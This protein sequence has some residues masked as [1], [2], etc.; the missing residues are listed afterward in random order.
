MS[1]LVLPTITVPTYLVAMTGG[2]VDPGEVFLWQQ[3][4]QETKKRSVQ[5]EENK[6]GTYVLV[7][8]KC[9]PKLGSKIQGS[10]AFKAANK[11]QDV[12]ALLLIV[13]SH[14]CQFNNHQQ[15]TWTL[16]QAKH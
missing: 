5:L 11:D 6:K 3:E 14:C 16:K 1:D 12:V 4:V 8:G 10:G 7:I 15:G 9:S 13:Q 2:Q